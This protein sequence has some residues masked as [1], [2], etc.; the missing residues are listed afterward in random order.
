MKPKKHSHKAVTTTPLRD[1]IADAE[2][3]IAEAIRQHRGCSPDDAK[4][5]LV[6]LGEQWFSVR[7]LVS[8]RKRVTKLLP[9]VD[10]VL[11]ALQ[12]ENISRSLADIPRRATALHRERTSQ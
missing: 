5:H 1:R 3:E 6:S 9:R 2:S 8:H 12:L 7:A 11:T 4:E 10:G